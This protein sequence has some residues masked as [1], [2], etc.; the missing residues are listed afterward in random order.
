MDAEGDT[1]ERVD[2]GFSELIVFSEI[3]DFYECSAA[4]SSRNR[5]GR[6]G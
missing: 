5:I 4:A 6:R 3:M 1:T 2:F